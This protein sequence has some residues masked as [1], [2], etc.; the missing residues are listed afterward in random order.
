MKFH[1]YMRDND[2]NRVIICILSSCGPQYFSLGAQ[3]ELLLF[4]KFYSG[5]PVGMSLIKI[6]I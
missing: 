1:E 6:F 4:Y 2:V 3:A 5:Q